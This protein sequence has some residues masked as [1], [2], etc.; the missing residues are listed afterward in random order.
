MSELGVPVVATVIGEAFGGALALGVANRVMMLEYATYS[1]IS[2]EGCA[3]DLVE[4]RQSG[5]R[6]AAEELK[7]TAA[8]CSASELS[9]P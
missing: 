1:V 5:V 3:S 8:D 9:M 7:I 2:P 4:G 6:A